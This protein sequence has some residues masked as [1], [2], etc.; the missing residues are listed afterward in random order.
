[1]GQRW[2]ELLKRDHEVTERVFAAMEATFS[3]AEGPPP[4]YSVASGT[5]RARIC[6][7]RSCSCSI[8]PRGP[9]WRGMPFASSRGNRCS[10]S[11][12]LWQRS[13]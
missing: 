8:T 1:M 13:T 12:W 7:A 11:F 9:P 2:D 5:S 6:C 3:A 10:S 4:A